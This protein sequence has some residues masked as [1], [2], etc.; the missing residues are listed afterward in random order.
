MTDDSDS[1]RAARRLTAG[2]EQ[3]GA[4]APDLPAFKAFASRQEADA[5]ASTG[6]LG[7]AERSGAAPGDSF[8]ASAHSRVAAVRRQSLR[9][10]AEQQ[11]EA[12]AR[13]VPSAFV[14]APAG[15]AAPLEDDGTSLNRAAEDATS[16]LTPSAS[17]S[18]GRGG[19][20]TGTVEDG[21]SAAKMPDLATDNPNLSRFEEELDEA[22]GGAA[23]SDAESVEG[24]QQALAGMQMQS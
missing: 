6:L 23:A 8:F 9:R 10:R 24:V 3:G 5:G 17:G 1:L 4:S 7:M 21:G 22:G 2:D 12:E 20:L 18:A 15:G 13:S 16:A 11:R 14:G 19:L